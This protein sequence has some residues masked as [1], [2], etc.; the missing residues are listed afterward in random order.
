MTNPGSV[1]A[2]AGFKE[3]PSPP[4]WCEAVR[5]LEDPPR[6]LPGS[7]AGID[8]ARRSQ[9]EWIW[10][11]D[12][13]SLPA[14]DALSALLAAAHTRQEGALPAIVAGMVIDQLGAPIRSLLAAGREHETALVVELSEQRLLPIRHASLA[15]TLVRR[16]ALLAHGLPNYKRLGR[17]AGHEW[18][19]RVLANSVGYLA[20]TSCATARGQGT[21]GAP[22]KLIEDLHMWRT[23]TWTR[24]DTLKA[25]QNALRSL[26]PGG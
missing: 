3:G 26:K 12:G 11:L 21:S 6:L 5:L 18:T 17:H 13:G 19:A 2:V 22:Q 9:Y 16:D 4:Q 8:S 1:L 24:G 14:P 15:N 20:P 7:G 23:G 25:T 10:V